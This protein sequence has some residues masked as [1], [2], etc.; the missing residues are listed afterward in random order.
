M[1]TT[2]NPKVQA[3]V[4]TCPPH[5][6]GQLAD[7]LEHAKACAQNGHFPEGS[8][9]AFFNRQVPEIRAILAAI[10]EAAATPRDRPFVEKE[11]PAERFQSFGLDPSTS[12]LIADALDG[13]WV[14]HTLQDRMGTDADTPQG[15]LTMREQLDAAYDHHKGS[16][17]D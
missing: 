6:R 12:C 11:T 13:Q 5:L 8:V 2:R 15:E 1:M 10:G 7:V 4:N 14:A 17:N 16:T 3:I 9:G